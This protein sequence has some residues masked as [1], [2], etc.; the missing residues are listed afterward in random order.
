MKLCRLI[1]VVFLFLS[2][3]LSS[4][5]TLSELKIFGWR[6]HLPWQQAQWVTQ[7]DDKLYIATQWALIEVD[8]AERSHRFITKVDGLAE[9]GIE[10]I[11]FI[12]SENLLFIVYTNSN[13]D[14]IDFNTD[15][16]VNLPLIKNNPNLIGDKKIYHIYT[17][18]KFAWLSCGFGMVKLNLQTFK[19]DLTLFTPNG[20]N[21]FLAYQGQ[22]YMAL[23]SAVYVIPVVEPNPQD[24]SRWRKLGV[25]D[26]WTPSLLPKYLTEHDGRVYF[27]SSKSVYRFTTDTAP[28]VVV[29]DPVKDF[30]YLSKEGEGLVMGFKK[31]FVGPVL[32]LDTQGG[33]TRIEQTCDAIRPL[34]AIEA[35]PR[36][37]WLADNEAGFSYYDLPQNRCDKLTFNS[38]F[39]H[40][41][42]ELAIT[43][44]GSLLVGTPGPPSNLGAPYARDGVYKLKDGVWE[45]IYANTYPELVPH[46]C[47]FD[48][49]RVAPIPDSDDFYVGSWVGGLSHFTAGEVECFTQHNSPLG[50]AGI[51]GSNRTAIGGLAFDRDGNLW[52]SNYGSNNPISVRKPDG[53]FLRL[54]APNIDLLSVTIDQNGYKWFVLAFN[55]GIMVYDS[56]AKLDDPS[57][58]RFRLIN[59]SNSVLPTNTVNAITVD[60][61]GDVWVGTAQGAISFECGSNVFD[62]N[63]KGSRRIV[64]VNGFNGYLLATEDVRAI[65]V[66][67]ANR[68]W[69]GTGNGIFVQSASG[70]DQVATYTTTNSPLFD[71]GINAIAINQKNGEVFIGTEKGLIS[72][73]TDAVGGT[74]INRPAA[75]AYPNPVRPEYSGPIAVYGVAEDADIKIT[76]ASGKLVWQGQANGGQAIWNGN[77]YTGRRVATGVYLVFATSKN[78][79]DTPDAAIMKIV[80]IH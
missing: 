56:G 69:F 14:I 28:E 45:R 20:V 65:A 26:G 37:F 8:K 22:Y 54:N 74:K 10:F 72:L 73:R 33:I 42:E 17:E 58:D 40:R 30:L 68:K 2:M 71:S 62:A 80:F 49:W 67:G 9:N 39:A 70:N 52:I 66:D 32:Y 44:E 35:S 6:E 1:S 53:S 61:S 4:Q 34:F 46:E 78:T 19:T 29:T 55:A 57:D 77:D 75:Y 23:D 59:T 38:P 36:T 47:Q 76:D 3:R 63:C 27:G 15:E 18:G 21:S 79:F 12:K 43:D 51:S 24:F 11:K 16:I 60:R 13:L 50:N 48:M 41:V 64:T 7:S 31:D 5:D 25:A